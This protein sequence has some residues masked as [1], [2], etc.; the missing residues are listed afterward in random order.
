MN[1]PAMIEQLENRL[2]LTSTLT[3]TTL[4]VVGTGGDDSIIVSVASND[5]SRYVVNESGVNKRFRKSAVKTIRIDGRAGADT[6]RINAGVAA[7]LNISG[8]AGA[9]NITGSAAHETIAGSGGND[10]ILGG[11][12]HD[13]LTGGADDDSLRGGGGNDILYGDQ[14]NDSLFGE[15]GA[16]TL[17]GDDEDTLRFIG[18]PTP[19]DIAGND[20]LDGGAGVDWLLG[21][22]G[23][24]SLTDANGFDTM[25]GGPGA[26]II[27]RR[28][29]D[30][31]TPDLADED[32][33]PSV[34]FRRFSKVTHT[35]AILTIRVRNASGGFDT[36]QIPANI[37]FFPTGLSGLHTHEGDQA[38]RIHFESI[39]PNDSYQLIEFFR[40]WG[41]SFDQR[42]IGRQVLPPSKKLKFTVNGKA[43]NQFGNLFPGDEVNIVI[44]VG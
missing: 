25:T 40:G 21:G 5:P 42:H 30:D 23:N 4:K 24:T 14:G 10:V 29:F 6:I 15:N 16:D 28:G 2:F 32:F 18:Q 34:E 27:D 33:V 35:H 20:A 1:R 31:E 36:A 3:G 19:Q 17:G 7:K 41:V 9:D 22:I 37:G 11:G 43:N 44:E 38:G 26:D 13:F 8:G 39:V 12:G